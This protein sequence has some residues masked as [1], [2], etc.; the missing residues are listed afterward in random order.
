VI[1]LGLTSAQMVTL[2][3]TLSGTHSMHVTVQILTLDGA[4]LADVSDRLL[5]GQVNIDWGADVTRSCTLSLL[6]PNRALTFD[7]SSPTDGALYV[8]RMIQV[9]YSVKAPGTT[10][11]TDIPVFCGPISKMDRASDVVNLEAQGKE[12]LALGAAWKVQTY[13]R[14][15]YRVDVIRSILRDLAGETKF[16]FPE[17]GA[18][19]PA[20]L[21]V[22]RESVPWTV[23]RD[24]SR[25]LGMQLF[26][27]GRGVCRL[28]TRPASAIFTFQSGDGGSVLTTPQVTY[29]TENLRNIVWVR[30]AGTIS[31]AKVAPYSHPLSP[32]KL[33]RNGVPRYL[34]EAVTEDT[35]RTAAE[36]GDLAAK[37]LN[38]ALLSSVEVSFDALPMPHLEPGDV[39][40]VTTPE[41]SNSFSLT[42]LSIPLV[43]GQAMSINYL[44]NVS[45]NVQRIR[46]T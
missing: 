24:V 35:I 26:Y 3:N 15:A 8:D 31:V 45:P 11:W 43:V 42:Q 29:S 14:G 38:K 28:R 21:S 46:R 6:D 19:L 41:F 39:A 34:L 2:N 18:R 25:G 9:V 13:K 30:G 33:G 4:R 17:H 32:Q 7:S 22:G 23:A 10:T 44:A 1:P 16:T 40:R 12:S 20:D 5:S 37:T 27:D 36:A